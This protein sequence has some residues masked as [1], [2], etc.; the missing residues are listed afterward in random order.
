MV[1]SL[2]PTDV[3]TRKPRQKNRKVETGQRVP[4][5]A[6]TI[7]AHPN[8]L[9]MGER[10]VLYALREDHPI[11]LSRRTPDFAHPGQVIGTPLNDPYLSRTPLLFRTKSA[12]SITLDPVQTTTPIT[13]DGAELRE[14]R[15][16]SNN[17]LERGITIQLADRVLL[18]LHVCSREPNPT[19]ED[20][21]LIGFSDSILE[22][23]DEIRNVRDLDTPVLLRGP[24]GTG[25]EL[26]AQAIHDGNATKGPFIS[27]NMSAVPPS[28]A[29]AELFGAA[30]GSFTGSS[31]SQLGFFRAAHGGTLFLDEIGDTPLTIQTMLLRALETGEIQAVGS[32]TMRK[33]K[34]RLIAATDSNLEA[35]IENQ[36]FRAPLY[37]RLS[38]YVIQL[39]NLRCRLDDLGRLFLHFAKQELNQMGE[40]H[41]LNDPGPDADPWIPPPLMTQ[42][43]R[44]SW[45][46]NVRQLRN[47]VRQLIIGSRD[48][49]QLQAKGM[50]RELLQTDSAT[51]DIAH[52]KPQ[53][54]R[55]RQIPTATLLDVLKRN[56]WDIKAS[57]T[58]LGISRGSLYTLIDKTPGLR[59]A[60]DLSA[61]EIESGYARHAG[62]LDALAEEFRVSHRALRRRIHDLN[63]TF[64][65]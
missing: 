64:P 4:H 16:F 44:F 35:H 19:D 37:H 27:V 30:K 45:P 22:V 36:T 20:L 2:R 39:P 46:G 13:L 25:K 43:V 57:A 61:E 49:Q 8:P 41:R 17:D 18:L 40:L 62:D 14:A 12:N 50:I 15:T 29:A 60:T 32:Q 58:A 23:R 48:M 56:H 7:L 3:P 28:L 6:L 54:L 11:S 21:G 5:P 24:S 34:V 59:K 51:L 33:V 1:D 38:G 10:A 53:D 47:V 63:L 52:E 55:P 31:R 9:R 65:N 26:A 42:L